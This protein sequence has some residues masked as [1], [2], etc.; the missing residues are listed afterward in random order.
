MVSA[1]FDVTRRPVTGW[2]VFGLLA[3]PVRVG[4]IT[5][6]IVIVLIIATGERS[7]GFIAM[8]V[9]SLALLIATAGLLMVEAAHR[10]RERLAA[11]RQGAEFEKLLELRTRELSELS[12]HLQDLAE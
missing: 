12:T 6:L 8:T 5:A 7:G 10:E 11:E 1:G 4:L 2:A 3:L 9:V